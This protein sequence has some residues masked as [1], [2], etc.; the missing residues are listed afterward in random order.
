MLLLVGALV[1]GAGCNGEK[2]QAVRGA[3]ATLPAP[4]YKKWFDAYQ[5]ANP[6]RRVTY[7]AVGSGP[8]IQEFT[9]NLV[10]FG[11]SDVP[12]TD[13][14][15]AQVPNKDVQLIPMAAVDIVLAYNVPG[16][17]GELKLS[18]EAYVG[19]FLGTITS[20]DDSRIAEQNK[21]VSLPSLPI[22][23]IRR[24][25]AS[26]TTAAFSRHLCAVSEA[27][28]KGPGDSLTSS[29]WPAGTTARGNQ[30]V[31]EAV[32]KTPGAI[33]YLDFGAASRAN[34]HL[35]SLENKAGQ[36]IQPTIESGQKTL[37]AINLESLQAGAA[38]PDGKDCYPIVTL[39]WILAH[40]HYSDGNVAKGLK[41][42][43]HYGLTE[44]QAEC[45]PMNYLP[46]PDALRQEAL[47]RVEAIGN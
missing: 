9:Y 39:T 46:L 3:G 16:V 43:L 15:V 41:E 44:G 38:D 42:L 28:K 8:G 47:R 12:L 24:A 7:L 26:G 5:E 27:W 45:K 37:E 1:C 20:W 13:E 17:T 21:G 22:K 11:A 25:G 19:I 33:G 29:N 2:S 14:Q 6:G 31:A 32:A 35:A 18:R 36:F 23:V 34:L 30:G 4:L 40:K 10:D